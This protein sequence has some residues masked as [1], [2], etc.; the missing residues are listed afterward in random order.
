M[1]A[2]QFKEMIRTIVADELKRQLPSVVEHILAE[3]YLRRIVAEN[4]TVHNK[5][6]GKEKRNI[7]LSNVLA[8][9]SDDFDEHIPEPMDNENQGIYQD[10]PLTKGKNESRLL[11]PDNHLSF[12]YEGVKPLSNKH[13]NDEGVSLGVLDKKLG[14]DFDRIKMMAGISKPAQQITEVV[15]KH[16]PEL[17]RFVDTRQADHH[18]QQQTLS[19]P[20]KSQISNYMP[21]NSIFPD[22]PIVIGE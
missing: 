9:N 4:S 6:L 16:R 12:I 19:Q 11:S 5:D 13:T 10:N 20:R 18:N 22:K 14:T 7:N 2:S 21:D 1:K 17:D 3:K 15:R 8:D